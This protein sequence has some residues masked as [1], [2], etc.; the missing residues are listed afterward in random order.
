MNNHHKAVLTLDVGERRIGVALA[1]LHSR[2][3]APLTTLERS[4]STFD[5][6]H[7]LIDQHGV[8]ILVVGLPRGLDGQHTSQTVAVEEFK[9]E[10]ERTLSVP[11]YWQDEALTSRLAEDELKARGRPY[12]KADIDALSA[13]YIL[14]DFL[15]D[16]PEVVL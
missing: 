12:K 14:E 16:H 8:A 2:L 11:V 13:T 15:R 3:P 5:D 6:I 7:R 4:E 1:D 9:A 10:L